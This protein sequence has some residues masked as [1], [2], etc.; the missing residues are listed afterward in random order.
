MFI[1]CCSTNLD[2]WSHFLS[3]NLVHLSAD[4]VACRAPLHQLFKGDVRFPG[5]FG[6]A[7]E[8]DWRKKLLASG[9]Q[10]MMFMSHHGLFFLHLLAA[11]MRRAKRWCTLTSWAA[12]GNSDSLVG[13]SSPFLGGSKNLMFKPPRAHGIPNLIRSSLATPWTGLRISGKKV[14]KEFINSSSILISKFHWISHEFHMKFTQLSWASTSPLPHHPAH[15]A[16]SRS[17]SQGIMDT[18]PG[19]ATENR[20]FFWMYALVNHRLSSFTIYHHSSFIIIH[21]SSSF[22]I[23]HDHLSPLI[24]IHHHWSLL[25]IIHHH[26][27]SF[28]PINIVAIDAIDSSLLPEFRT[29]GRT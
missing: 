23:I 11:P 13:D 14:K 20:G 12:Q 2:Q 27:S 28:I 4:D 25:I 24:I 21:H 22:N 29:H 17:V 7:E 5:L 9:K 10:F 6:R 8:L 15:S 26:W 1:P 16:N 3:P 18:S 19:M